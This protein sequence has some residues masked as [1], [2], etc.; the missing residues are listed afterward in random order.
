MTTAQMQQNSPFSPSSPLSKRRQIPFLFPALPTDQNPFY[1]PP[2]DTK[3][4]P[5]WAAAP[6]RFHQRCFNPQNLKFAISPLKNRDL[7]PSFPPFPRRFSI[8]GAPIKSLSLIAGNSR[9]SPPSTASRPEG[10]GGRG[11]K[12]K[13]HPTPNPFLGGENTEVV[14]P[15][16]L[17]GFGGFISAF[18]SL[19]ISK[20]PPL[21]IA[22]FFSE[23]AAS[24]EATETNGVFLFLSLSQ[25]GFSFSPFFF[26]LRFYCKRVF[27]LADPQRIPGFPLQGRPPPPRAQFAAFTLAVNLR[28]RLRLCFICINPIHAEP[29]GQTW[30]QFGFTFGSEIQ[31]RFAFGNVDKSGKRLSELFQ[32]ASWGWNSWGLIW[33]STG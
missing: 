12:S 1:L 15:A 6:S 25:S 18:I 33:T 11:G 26:P 16:L 23:P 2:K 28:H 8:W 30:L 21:Q 5:G 24:F 14:P 31:L 9:A 27:F 20:I 17:Q 4:F 19:L 29:G 13:T 3:P 10:E 22:F 32:N 7:P